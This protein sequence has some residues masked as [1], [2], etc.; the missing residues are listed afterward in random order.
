MPVAVMVF[1][2]VDVSRG[3]TA[4]VQ[5]Q[6]PDEAALLDDKGLLARARTVVAIEYRRT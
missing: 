2:M 6:D 4:K 1:G 5:L 3:S